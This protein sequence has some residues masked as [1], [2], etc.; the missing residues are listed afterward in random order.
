MRSSGPPTDQDK[1]VVL[2]AGWLLKFNDVFPT[3][4]KG[5][6]ARPTVF[7]SF[8]AALSDLSVD[9]LAGA[10]AEWMKTADHFPAPGEIRALITERQGSIAALAAEQSWDFVTW[11]VER[12]W[13][14]EGGMMPMYA[15]KEATVSPRLTER[16]VKTE[17]AFLDAYLPRPF[18]AQEDFAIRSAGGLQRIFEARGKDLDFVR[19]DFLKQ[20]TYFRQTNGLLSPPSEVKQIERKGG[21]LPL[22]E[23]E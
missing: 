10:F 7:D 18:T 15:G 19:R 14:P 20:F 23:T 12:F 21:F 1:R 9:E 5:I 6:E 13:K 17:Y 16:C 8:E 22:G 2:V 11:A 4:G 3:Y